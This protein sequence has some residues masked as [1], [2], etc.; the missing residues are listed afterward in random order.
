MDE[1]TPNTDGAM[2]TKAL[3]EALAKL[4]T[5]PSGIIGPDSADALASVLAGVI[6]S[7]TRGQVDFNR[8]SRFY[9]TQGKMCEY[10]EAYLEQEE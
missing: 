4:C 10:F 1:K 6:C 7:E 8:W 3:K 2:D 5:S 9:F